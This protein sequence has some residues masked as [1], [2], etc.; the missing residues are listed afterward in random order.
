MQILSHSNT[1][2]SYLYHEQW[3]WTYKN[4]YTKSSSLSHFEFWY[5]VM[6]EVNFFQ[7]E[8]LQYMLQAES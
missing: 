7:R 4:K 1:V 5:C 8:T 3:N 2:T 6:M